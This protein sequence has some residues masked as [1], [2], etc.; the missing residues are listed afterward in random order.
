[1]YTTALAMYT[2]VSANTVLSKAVG[3]NGLNRGSGCSG[4]LLFLASESFLKLS[5]SGS[6]RCHTPCLLLLLLLSGDIEVNP[7]PANCQYPIYS[8]AC[9]FC[10]DIWPLSVRVEKRRTGLLCLLERSLSERQR[11]DARRHR[12]RG[13][14][15]EGDSMQLG[16]WGAL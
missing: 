10:C 8:S 4:E 15:A 2:V 11:R 9:S 14:S 12:R 13:S 5:F 1:M 16:V 3:G 7:G 6:K